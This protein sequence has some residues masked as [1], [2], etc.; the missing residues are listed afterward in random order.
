M[1]R[2][3]FKKGEKT[4]ISNKMKEYIPSK[5]YG[6][7]LESIGH[8]FTDFEEAAI[9]YHVI[10]DE[11]LLHNELRRVAGRTQDDILKH[12]IEEYLSYERDRINHFYDNSERDCVY[13]VQTYDKEF[14]EDVVLAYAYSY[15]V[16][17][18]IGIIENTPFEIRKETV[19]KDIPNTKT[20]EKGFFNP[21][22]SGEEKV[23]L[24]DCAVVVE[25]DDYT[26]CE[27]VFRF[28]DDG[29]LEDYYS[30]WNNNISDLEDV[31][32]RYSHDYFYNAFIKFPSPFEKGCFVR[33]VSNS[34]RYEQW[35]DDTIIGIVD[36]SKEEWQELI[37]QSK[38]VYLDA[39]DASITVQFLK[40][41]GEFTHDHISPLLLENVVI[42]QDEPWY[43]LACVARDMILGNADI[44]FF[45]TCQN[46]YKAS[47]IEDA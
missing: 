22:L 45:T 8:S 16:A 15:D 39:S 44:G 34:K 24:E 36:T 35:R 42:S 14:Q 12:Q 13:V 3:F 28:N 21:Y 27:G 18:G 38:G 29:V 2:C 23:N 25:S 1:C 37:E 40:K 20:I 46:N 33:F 10:E 47:L 43:E 32:R 6:D 5:S 9:L 7:Y 31:E 11:F 26:A 19:L 41:D 17:F 4:V 30:N